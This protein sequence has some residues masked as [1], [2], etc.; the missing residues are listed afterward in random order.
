MR[1]GLWTYPQGDVS[2]APLT[3]TGRIVILSFLCWHVFRWQRS[4]TEGW[5][6]IRSCNMMSAIEILFS[7]ERPSLSNP[8]CF[9]QGFKLH[10]V[11]QPEVRASDEYLNFVGSTGSAGSHLQ[12]KVQQTSITPLFGH[13]KWK[14]IRSSTPS[15][16][17]HRMIWHAYSQS[18]WRLPGIPYLLSP[19]TRISNNS[20]SLV[21]ATTVL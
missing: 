4:K 14:H 8:S 11:D 20:W 15:P 16:E 18:H 19:N 10:L 9:A 6:A 17:K 5:R 2:S 13:L 7:G 21:K 3:V 12:I 1:S